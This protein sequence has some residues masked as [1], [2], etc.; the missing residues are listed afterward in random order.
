MTTP[1]HEQFEK[2][3]IEHLHIFGCL[4]RDGL[5]DRCDMA[6]KE[7]LDFL[8]TAEAEIRADER[9]RVVEEINVGRNPDGSPMAIVVNAT[10]KKKPTK[11]QTDTLI[12]VLK[13]NGEFPQDA[14]KKKPSVEM[15]EKDNQGTDE[16]YCDWYKCPACGDTFITR[17]SKYCGECGIKLVWVDEQAQ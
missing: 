8:R 2:D 17:E 12:Q 6:Q 4:F 5:M 14:P 13:D 15:G 1:L 16:A 7:F 11:E 9:A 10:T 3:A